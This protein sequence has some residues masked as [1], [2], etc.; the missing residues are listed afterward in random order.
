MPEGARRS[1]S[2]RVGLTS[3]QYQTWNEAASVDGLEGRLAD[4]VR[5]VVNAR[6]GFRQPSTVGQP[7]E[8]IRWRDGEEG[9]WEV[10]G[11]DEMETANIDGANPS[12]F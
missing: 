7:D 3:L 5:S 1:Q 8:V 10:T 6:I 2:V 9:E 4:W 12:P 11:I